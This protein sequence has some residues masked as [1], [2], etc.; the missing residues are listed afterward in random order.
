MICAACVGRVE[1][2]LQD[3]PGGTSVAVNLALDQATVEVLRGTDILSA[4]IA[5]SRNSGTSA[6]VLHPDQTGRGLENAPQRSAGGFKLVLAALLT[7]PLALSILLGRFGL[8]L[9]VP[10]WLQFAL[11]APVQCW[12]GWSFYGDAYKGL[13]AGIGNM[14]LLVA[15]GTSAAFG[16]RLLAL[17]TPGAEHGAMYFEASA[18]IITLVLLGRR[19]QEKAKRRTS[20][21]IRALSGL[22]PDTARIWRGA[23][24]AEIPVAE[25]AVGDVVVVRPGERVAVDGRVREGQSEVDE[26]LI[27]GKS[28][29]VRKRLWRR[30]SGRSSQPSQARRPYNVWSTESARCSCLSSS[31]L[32]PSQ[33]SAGGLSMGTW[34]PP[35]SPGQRF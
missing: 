12:A 13:R 21:A 24:E 16:L 17:M 20:T 10:G 27:T 2:A 7:A 35:L 30:S 32:P 34:S 6:T 22:R 18:I 4:L 28:L 14:D 15:T 1:A 26:S 5:A 9:C 31:L 3:V 8:S 19:L 33:R 25:I 11:A 23:E 29:P